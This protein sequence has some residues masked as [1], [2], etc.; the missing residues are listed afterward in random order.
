MDET[1]VGKA[2]MEAENDPESNGV[3]ERIH[4]IVSWNDRWRIVG[5][6]NDLLLAV[7]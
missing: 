5:L 7:R 1:H 4:Q 6:R 2:R 3:R